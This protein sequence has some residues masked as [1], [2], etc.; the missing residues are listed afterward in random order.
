MASLT[1]FFKNGDT[2][3]L[4]GDPAP[5]REFYED[6]VGGQSPFIELVENTGVCLAVRREEVYSAIIDPGAPSGP[7]FFSPA[8]RVQVQQSAHGLNQIQ[9]QAYAAAQS[10]STTQAPENPTA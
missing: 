6:I 9:A 1:L 3:V 4:G 5:L 7:A 8:L 10:S 2:F